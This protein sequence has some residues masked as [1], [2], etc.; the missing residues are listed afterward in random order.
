VK[1]SISKCGEVVRAGSTLPPKGPPLWPPLVA[2]SVPRDN[3]PRNEEV[4]NSSVLHRIK[5]MPAALQT[6]GSLSFEDRV[7]ALW[8]SPKN[9]RRSTKRCSREGLLIAKIQ[10]DI[11]TEASKSPARLQGTHKAPMTASKNPNK[12][13]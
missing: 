11:A 4:M 2:H 9:A 1:M 12:T 10:G 7:A 5:T 13:L 8:H 3:A 6:R